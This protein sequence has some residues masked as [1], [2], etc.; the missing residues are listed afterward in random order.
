MCGMLYLNSMTQT[1]I[2]MQSKIHSFLLNY[3]RSKNRKKEGIKANVP[4]NAFAKILRSLMWDW[5][6]GIVKYE[7][8]G[9]KSP[10]VFHIIDMFFGKKVFRAK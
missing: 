1:I 3:L 2:P 9:K 5:E 4:I 10:L 7:R 8:F 6:K